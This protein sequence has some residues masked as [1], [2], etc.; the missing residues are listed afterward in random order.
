[1]AVTSRIGRFTPQTISA[2]P[3]DWAPQADPSC[4][5]MALTDM[6]GFSASPT[7]HLAQTKLINHTSARQ[8]FRPRMSGSPSPARCQCRW[9]ARPT[10]LPRHNLSLALF[11]IAVLIFLS[12]I[13]SSCGARARSFTS[14]FYVIGN[15]LRRPGFACSTPLSCRRPLGGLRQYPCHRR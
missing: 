10:P 9:E 13:S 3:A 7:T 12:A 1:M 5:E 15:R 6:C 2:N 8:V 4:Q 14:P 11:L